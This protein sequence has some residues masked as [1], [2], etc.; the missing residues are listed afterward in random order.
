MTEDDTPDLGPD[1]EWIMG[2]LSELTPLEKPEKC[3]NCWGLGRVSMMAVYE[4]PGV[5]ESM[6][7]Y[8][9]ECD[10]IFSLRKLSAEQ[11]HEIF[12][13]HRDK[14]K[15]IE[16]GA[17]SPTKLA[18]AADKAVRDHNRDTRDR[19]AV[20]GGWVTLALLIIWAMLLALRYQILL[21]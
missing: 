16:F 4:I 5:E 17:R 12:T 19:L 15:K 8:C 2:I 20:L 21:R 1:R 13:H 14:L 3:L 9:T 11:T 18:D 7:A 10:G 6:V